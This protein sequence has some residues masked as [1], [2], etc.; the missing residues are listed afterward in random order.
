MSHEILTSKEEFIRGTDNPSRYSIGMHVRSVNLML[1]LNVAVVNCE[2]YNTD[3]RTGGSEYGK[4]LTTKASL[5]N[6]IFSV[7]KMDDLCFSHKA[8]FL[9]CFCRINR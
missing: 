4:I 9:F 2:K 6:L 1:T 7:H 3:N 8:D 5:N